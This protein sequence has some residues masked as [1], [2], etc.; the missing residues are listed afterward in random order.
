MKKIYFLGLILFLLSANLQAASTDAF[1]SEEGQITP[2]DK[3][4]ELLDITL[5]QQGADHIV[6]RIVSDDF[7]NIVLHAT[8]LDANGKPVSGLIADDFTLTEQSTTETAPVSQSLT[9]FEENHANTK[10]AL[11][12]VFDISGSMGVGRRL[13][14][15][16]TAAINFLSNAQIG[17]RASLVTFS[18]CDEGKIVIPSADVKTDSDQNGTPDIVDAILSLKTINRTAL[19]DGIA[20]GIDS[21][22]QEAFPKGVI[23]F[24]DG[25]ANDDCHFSINEVIQK[26]KDNGISVYTIGLGNDADSQLPEIATETG[27]YF[28]GAPTAA[29]ME[30]LY[31]DIATIIRGQYTL[32]YTTHNPALDGTV[33]TVTLESEGRT[34]TGTYTA[35][36][37]P[38][39]NN[40][41]IVHTPITQ[42]QE[43]NA[44]PINA[45]VSDP[46][47]GDSITQVILSYRIKPAGQGAFTSTAM[48]NTAGDAYTATIPGSHVT[49]AGV[50]YYITAWDARE[51]SAGSGSAA[52][53]H[54]INVIAAP[55]PPIANAGADRSINEGDVITLDGS[56]SSA[57]TP[58]GQLTYAW[59]QISGTTV[60]I[61]NPD[62][63]RPMF[64]APSTGPAGATLVFRLIVTDSTN[65]TGADTV[66]IIVNDS[67]A[68]K[69]AFS[70]LPAAP[71]AEQSVAFTDNSIPEGGSIVSWNWDFGGMGISN[72]QNPGFAFPQSGTH[73]VRMTVTD[74]F[75]SVGTAIKTITVDE[76]PPAPCVGSDCNGSGGCFIQSAGAALMME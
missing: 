19:Y 28:R 31:N 22:T 41:T 49:L 63:A 72:H 14:D 42:W 33:R 67:L 20:N 60:V 25:K 71:V 35:P 43:N 65:R 68:P 52:S 9:C 2:T 13:S 54:M 61:S 53:P 55:L 51:G 66:I 40:P 7:P 23:V 3:S 17:D 76:P 74:E 1:L 46:D 39:P 48:T 26:A 47:A 58:D 21:I 5:V 29:D 73:S 6:M 57:S 10:I 11:A 62:E 38:N 64:N 15:A 69:A 44:I 32:C 75:G 56:G 18:G 37:N 16:K 34:G 27:G 8:V 24:T 50:Q 30:E 12:L 59:T 70:W 36:Q 45:Q 4:L